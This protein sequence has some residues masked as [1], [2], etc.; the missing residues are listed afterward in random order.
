MKTIQQI[1][2]L[3]L[4]LQ[5]LFRLETWPIIFADPSHKDIMLNSSVHLLL[6]TFR[7]PTSVHLP[8]TYFC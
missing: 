7:S 8:F 2:S 5:K 6:F 3:S 1:P 4:L